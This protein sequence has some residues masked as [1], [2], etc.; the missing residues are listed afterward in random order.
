MHRGGGVAEPVGDLGG[1]GLLDEIG[2]Q[3]FVAALS[4]AARLGEILRP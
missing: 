4:P 3:R 1:A 2:P